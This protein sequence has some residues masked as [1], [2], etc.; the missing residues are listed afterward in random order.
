MFRSVV[1]LGAGERR[2][3]G[4]YCGAEQQCLPTACSLRPSDYVYCFS[5]LFY[6][7][8]ANRASAA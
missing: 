5:V 6:I 8:V 1:G 2:S 3:Y 7:A 4:I